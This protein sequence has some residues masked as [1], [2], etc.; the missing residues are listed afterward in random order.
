[1]KC[2]CNCSF[3]KCLKEHKETLEKEL[4]TIINN[5]I[6]EHSEISRLY[7]TNKKGYIANMVSISQNDEIEVDVKFDD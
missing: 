3:N 7:I 4:S 5:W 6:K 2:C 1:M